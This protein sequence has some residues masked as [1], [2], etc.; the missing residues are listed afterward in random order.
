[1]L[2]VGLRN[3]GDRYEGTRHNIGAE[4]VDL[5]AERWSAPVGKGPKGVPVRVGTARVGDST[6]RLALP[7]TFMNES[8][9]AVQ[10]LAAYY[11][12]AA[13]DLLVLHDDI[14]LGFGRLRIAHDRGA[15]GHNGIRSITNALGAPAFWRLKI[16]VGRPPS[17]MDP[18]DFVLSRF[19]RAEREEVDVLVQDAADVVE[20]WLGDRERARELAASRQPR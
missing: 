17:R 4:V 9:R 14:D 16:G 10:P 20:A 19:S 11:D 7:T 8:G 3:P 13:D 12:V 15:G 1:M 5:L 18:A 6:V 2:V